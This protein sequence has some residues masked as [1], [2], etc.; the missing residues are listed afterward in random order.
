MKYGL[1]IGM[2]MQ[3]LGAGM[4]LLINFNFVYLLVGQSL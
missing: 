1:V 3:T 4:K 2:A